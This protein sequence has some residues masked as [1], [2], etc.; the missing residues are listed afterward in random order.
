MT[1]GSPGHELG[2]HLRRGQQ[3]DHR[4]VADGVGPGSSTATAGPAAG[5]ST[6]S[7]RSPQPGTETN[8]TD[9]E[10]DTSL[11]DGPRCDAEGSQGNDTLFTYNTD[12]EFTGVD[13]PDRRG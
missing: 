2:L 9:P 3:P 13:K 8:S 1:N 6:A 12:G 4:R 7:T 10:T 5:R 11:A